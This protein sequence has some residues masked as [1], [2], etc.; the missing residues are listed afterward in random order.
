MILKNKETE[1]QQNGPYMQDT[2]QYL[3][4]RKQ[5]LNGKKE[6]SEG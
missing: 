1:A 4:N 3:M 5:N 2:L 6:T